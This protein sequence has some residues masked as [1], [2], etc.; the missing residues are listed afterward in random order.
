MAPQP[1]ERRVLVILWLAMAASIAMYF[2]VIQRVQPTRAHENPA[3][4]NGLMVAAIGLVGTSFLVKS[5]IRAARG[6]RPALLIALALC[7]AA[8]LCGLVVWFN[9]A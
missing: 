5:R 2:V 4:L 1:A 6:E 8:A 9:T 7:E 3:L